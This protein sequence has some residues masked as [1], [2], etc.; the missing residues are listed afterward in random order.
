MAIMY[1]GLKINGV[2]FFVKEKFS[3]NN[4]V[5][6][7]SG[8]P[9]VNFLANLDDNPCK[10]NNYAKFCTSPSLDGILPESLIPQENSSPL[11]L[12]IG[13]FIIFKYFLDINS[14]VD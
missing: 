13:V 12:D 4:N 10:R 9:T 11:T 6:W 1:L 7:V 8:H 14:P 5:D 3:P 2:F